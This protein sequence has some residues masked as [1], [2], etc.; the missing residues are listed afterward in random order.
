MYVEIDPD[1]VELG[2]PDPKSGLSQ[3]YHAGVSVPRLFRFL[4][5]VSGVGTVRYYA[6]QAIEVRLAAMSAHERLAFATAAQNVSASETGRSSRRIQI[7]SLN[8]TG[9][10]A[11]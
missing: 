3:V 11:D 2:E 9:S 7:P 10:D 1:L 4:P 8:R 5:P 6:A